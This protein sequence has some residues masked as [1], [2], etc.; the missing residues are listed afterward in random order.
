MSAPFLW[1]LLPWIISLGLLALLK[2]P[3]MSKIISLVTSIVLFLI[4]VLQ[5]IGDV[6]KVGPLSLNIESTTL[7]F[8]RELTLENSDRFALSVIFFVLTIYIAAYDT[9]NS[10]P[11]FIPLS[12]MIVSLLVAAIAV[13]P[14]LYAAVFVEMA[15]LMMIPMV[16]DKDNS[17]HKGILTFIIFQALAIPFVLFSGWIVG[18]TQASPSD[19]LRLAIAA[20]SLLLGFG[21]WLAVFPFHSWVPQFSQIIKPYYSGFIFSLLPVVILLIVVEYVS[22]LTW[23]RDGSFVGPVL[24]TVGIIMIVSSGIWASV[25]KH[26]PRLLAYSVLYETGFALLLIS[27]RSEYGSLLLSHSFLPRIVALMAISFS[28]S[29]LNQSGLP[30]SF[31]GVRGLIKRFPFSAIGL[32]AAS[33]SIIGVPLFAGFPVKFEVLQNLG[34]ISSKP[35]LW[36]LAG[37]AGF[38]IAMLRLLKSIAEPSEGKFEINETISQRLILVIGIVLLGIMG[39]FPNF[40]P[41]LFSGLLMTIPGLK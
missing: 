31:A 5:S 3:V 24:Q 25:E 19:E 39:L 1:I 23:L 34:T 35:V 6:I 8:G 40:P 15:T 18:G 20:F 21:F 10:P 28:L 17:G 38:T 29:I 30:L 36:I 37:V 11:K 26:L 32:L 7:F 33:L 9:K 4:S 12:M 27:M 14:F 41:N 16:V 2:R 13:Q 22:S